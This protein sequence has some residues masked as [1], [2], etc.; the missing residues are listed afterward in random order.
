VYA[1]VLRIPN[2]DGNTTN[3]Y[4]AWRDDGSSPTYTSGSRFY[5]ADSGST[6]TADTA[7]DFM[8]AE[9]DGR[10]LHENHQGVINAG[11]SFD[12]TNW[13]SSSFTPASSFTLY[14][15]AIPLYRGSGDTPGACTVEIYAA[16]GDQKPT[17]SALATGTISATVMDALNE[18]AV[19]GT[20]TE[21]S[22]STPLN[23]V[24]STEYCIVVYCADAGVGETA[25]WN[26]NTG[27][28]TDIETN[29][30]SDSG[31]SWAANSTELYYRLYGANFQSP[32]SDQRVTTRIV[33]AVGNEIW[34]GS[35]EALQRLDA[36]V[37]NIDTSQPIQMFELL[38]KCFIANGTNLK[39]VDFVNVKIT[40]TNIGGHP[41]DFATVLT[42]GTSGAQ[43][44]VDYIDAVAGATT[45]YGKLMTTAEFEAETVT[46]TDDDGNAISFTGTA[47]VGNT[48]PHWYNWTVFGNSAVF[49]TMPSQATLGKP[50]RSRPVLSGDKDYP[51]YWYMGRQGNPWDWNYI[52]LDSQSPVAS[53]NADA[54]QTGEPIIAV[55]PYSKDKFIY[56]CT[57]SIWYN[58]G[59]PADNI[60]SESY[61]DF[62]KDLAYDSQL[63]KLV[64]GYDRLKDGFKVC[65]TTLAT[66]ANENWWFDI[67][68][69]GLFP[70]TYPTQC[71]VFCL[72]WYEALDPNYR[73]LLHG[74]NDGFVR[75][76]DP[77]AVDD[78][79]GDS[80]QAID[81]Y[82]TFG[83]IALGQ[84]N[85]EGV[86]KSLVGITTGS[87]SGTLLTD[88]SPL[89]CKV[90]TGL[91]ADDIV[92]K[93]NLNTSPTMAATIGAPG[94]N[95]G[96]SIKRP[97]RGVFAG[98]R[99]GNSTA[100]QT[101]GLDALIINGRSAGK[102]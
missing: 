69:K 100:A 63:H 95:R 18:S 84:E 51:Q 88:S 55:V 64:C 54:G 92:E 11:L 93:F 43:M 90:W 46:G 53:D 32:L 68:K 24:A 6:W 61:P 48:I 89:T 20:W 2:D 3:E 59:D 77:T 91:A 72:Y 67:R 96:Q 19:G 70:E 23:V 99:L 44:V 62:I 56:G 79:I 29:V 5:S 35:A 42:G 26:G 39:V 98:I 82:V 17:G 94:R 76:E 73:C 50:W 97:V 7:A 45:I 74:C 12:D 14:S 4:W 86:L 9:R 47:Q 8:F 40:T 21:V 83:P 28:R 41:P 34:Y 66:G 57:N 80:D 60:T 75:Y 58:Q 13:L 25:H 85:G 87:R 101:W 102:V 78:N 10:K 71:G 49:G 1:I 36:S 37:D 81:S 65:K 15:L 31:S 52:S 38:G 22:L 33:E 27:A 30:S 16:D